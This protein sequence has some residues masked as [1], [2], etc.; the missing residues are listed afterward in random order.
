MY[1][2][3]SISHIDDASRLL[4]VKK[5]L[6]DTGAH[7]GNYIGRRFKNS[8]LPF[9]AGM[10]K[11]SDTSVFLADAQTEL[12]I[13][14]SADLTL[15]ITT[16]SGVMVRISATFFVIDSG[17]DL[18]LGLNDMIL[19]APGALVDMIQRAVL[20]SK[21]EIQFSALWGSTDSPLGVGTAPPSGHTV[22]SPSV[23][24]PHPYFR[25]TTAL[26]CDGG[27]KGSTR[28]PSAHSVQ[29]LTV[30]AQTPAVVGPLRAYEAGT[31]DIRAPWTNIDV[32]APEEQDPPET[33]LF[34]VQ[35][36]AF[37]EMPVSEATAEYLAA[38]SSAPA[39][40]VPF[41]PEPILGPDGMPGPA[42][43]RGRFTP[44]MYGHP[45]FLEYMRTEAIKVFVPQNWEGIRV[46]PIEFQFKASLPEVHYQKAR[47]IPKMRYDATKREVERLC[48]YHLVPSTSSIV[49]AISVADKATHPYIRV[50]GDYRKINEHVNLDHQYIPRVQ[51]ELERFAKFKYFVDLDMVNSFHQFKLGLKTSEVLSLIT[52]WG[53]FRPVFMPEGVSPATGVLQANMREIFKDFSDWAVVIFD[54]FCIGGES[55]EDV[56]SKF[57]LFVERCIL[58]NI[59]LKFSKCYFGFKDVKFFGYLCDGEGWQIDDERKIAIRQ[60]PFP[61]GL[62][63]GDCVTRMQSFL[64]FSLYFRDFVDKYSILAAPLYGM[65]V[66]GFIWDEALWGDNDY[67]RIF[68]EFKVALC[69]C[70]KLIWPNYE[71]PWVLQTDASSVGCG[72]ILFQIRTITDPITGVITTRR[73]P[74]ACIS[75]KFSGA[76]TNWAV[77]KQEMYAIYFAVDKLAYYLRYKSF[78]IQTDHANLVHME[79][80]N[81][82]IMVRWRLFLQSFPIES[83]IH[84]AG[85]LNIAADFFSRIMECDYDHVK[86]DGLVEA[87]LTHVFSA[88]CLSYA[89]SGEPILN[90]LEGHSSELALQFL[91]SRQGACYVPDGCSTCMEI[92]DLPEV[93]DDSYC[94]TCGDDYR[95]LAN[96]ENDSEEVVRQRADKNTYT[97]HVPAWDL[98]LEKIHGGSAMHWAALPTWRILR[99]NFEHDIPFAYVEYYVRECATCQK[100]RKTLNRDRHLPLTRHLKVSGPRSTLG[101]DGFTMTPVDKYGHSYLHVI[102]NYFTKHVFLYVC[103]DK[104]AVTG[105]DAIIT[106]MALFGRHD[107]LQSDPGSDY[108]SNVVAQLNK[109][110]GY[111][112]SFSLVDRPESNGVEPTNRE[113]ARHVKAIV[114]DKGLQEVWSEPRTLAVVAFE[115]NNHLSSESNYTAFQLTFGSGHDEYF[116][117]LGAESVNEI[118]RYGPYIKELDALISK[119]RALSLKY[120]SDLA[121]RRTQD[122]GLVKRNRWQPGDHVLL[123]NVSPVDKMQAP[124][125]GP[126]QVD[127]QS[128]N[129][130]YLKSLV[131]GSVKP[132]HVGRLSL[133]TGTQEEALK[134]ARA[135][136]NQHFIERISGYRGDS[137]TRETMEFLVE[138]TDAPGSWLAYSRDLADTEQFESY[139]DSLPQLRPLISLASEVTKQ[140]AHINKS[141]IADTHRE[142]D[143]IYVDLRA[144][145]IY[146]SEW[147][148]ALG[149]LD[150]INIKHRFARLRVGKTLRLPRIPA[151]TRVELVDETFGLVHTVDPYTLYVHGTVRSID[152][153]PD[154]NE[155]VDADFARAHPYRPINTDLHKRIVRRD[156]ATVIPAAETIRILSRNLNGIRS[157]IAEGFLRELA[158]LPGGPPDILV[159]QET[160]AHA[161]DIAQLE[162]QLRK[163]G[164]VH[165]HLQPGVQSGYAGVAIACKIRFILLESAPIERGRALAVRVYGWTLIIF[166]APIMCT[167]EDLIVDRRAKFDAAALAYVSQL[168]SPQLICGDMNSVSD[169]SLDLSLPLRLRNRFAGFQTANETYLVRALAAKGFVDTFRLINQVEIAYT[170]FPA[171]SWH[172]IKARLDYILTDAVLQREVVDCRV[173]PRT[174]ASDHAGVLLTILKPQGKPEMWPNFSEIFSTP[175]DSFRPVTSWAGYTPQQHIPQQPEVYQV[176]MMHIGPMRNG[177]DGAAPPPPPP[178]VPVIV[179]ESAAD[180]EARAIAL[181][182]VPD[183]FLIAAA[184]A[185]ER[186]A[187]MDAAITL[188]LQPITMPTAGEA[189]PNTRRACTPPVATH[190]LTTPP[191]SPLSFY[192]DQPTPYE[193]RKAKNRAANPA[194]AKYCDDLAA[195]NA[196]IKADT[197]EFQRTMSSNARETLARSQVEEARIAAQR[198]EQRDA[199]LAWR[200]ANPALWAQREAWDARQLLERQQTAVHVWREAN[201]DLWAQRQAWD[202]EQLRLRRAR[203]TSSPEILSGLTAPTFDLSGAEEDARTPEAAR[204]IPL[205]EDHRDPAGLHYTNDH[206]QARLLQRPA[207]LAPTHPP[208]DH[209]TQSLASLVMHRATTPTPRTQGRGSRLGP[210]SPNYVD[211]RRVPVLADASI[212]VDNMP[213]LLSDDDT[214]PPLV[215][216]DRP[217]SPTSIAADFEAHSSDDDGVLV[218]IPGGFRSYM[219]YDLS[220]MQNGP[221]DARLIELQN[222]LNASLR[223]DPF[224]IPT[225]LSGPVT[226]DSWRSI[227]EGG[228]PIPFVD[229]DSF[230]YESDLDTASDLTIDPPLL[231]AFDYH[232]AI[233]TVEI[234]F[235]AGLMDADD[236]IVAP[237]SYW[238]LRDGAIANIMGDA[239]SARVTIRAG[240]LIA[241]F[242]GT[243]ISSADARQLPHG[244][245]NYLIDMQDGTVLDC[246][247]NA[248]ARPALCLASIGNM[249]EGAFDVTNQRF[250]SYNDNNAY[251]H[252]WQDSDGE[253]VA[254]LYAVRQIRGGE[255]VMWHYGAKYVF[256]FEVST[257]ITSSS[258]E[259]VSP[260]VGTARSVALSVDPKAATQPLGPVRR[261]AQVADR[262]LTVLGAEEAQPNAS[263]DYA[264]Q[265]GDDEAQEDAFPELAFDNDGSSDESDAG[266]DDGSDGGSRSL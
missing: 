54:N 14:E 94:E 142:H 177:D 52:P 83:I 172:G 6:W 57:K 263:Q 64:G 56:F 239:L 178:P 21:A 8:N 110:L 100:Y 39:A 143:V 224:A 211:H 183:E 189:D 160:K 238:A 149:E 258:S 93:C 166:Y 58:F 17:C 138:F 215:G 5:L 206:F 205:R 169:I 253:T 198:V 176:W 247:A 19:Q 218:V 214:P 260:D 122:K 42:P 65:T 226:I 96:L 124:R 90:E 32:V 171:G 79:R 246:M 144:R 156:L 106:Y 203:H 252:W 223:S 69:L 109:Y 10:L 212:S 23:A 29:T 163:L 235:D 243:R 194:F 227:Y 9:L 107:R 40:S 102:V 193:A 213:V 229:S 254:T 35:A 148:L 112:H 41:D 105:A 180:E 210:F 204:G 188:S 123:D 50:C 240:T 161:N 74:I 31:H 222:E 77:I 139:C 26:L 85:K 27:G 190:P 55:L 135:D 192:G 119:V 155:I 236:L 157:A 219:S 159:L 237:S 174:P 121:K 71:L 217:P 81:V 82:A 228:T 232:Y 187:E 60:I 45:G 186:E 196:K 257:I 22:T 133:Y 20:F 46:K 80:S 51:H 78:Q 7:G 242:R 67:R 70:F 208:I 103:K 130:V 251:V 265:D 33:S 225:P 244:L 53:T 165:F 116:R 199:M 30:P 158:E 92:C 88:A 179:E 173:L 73:E 38:L 221:M 66:K 184:E 140:K 132:F 129:E 162:N 76:A 200:V 234:N 152:D 48:K 168:P 91:S 201:P 24:A 98:I 44:D 209:L 72:A 216:W 87:A 18:I 248:T 147:Y 250:L 1:T 4:P 245:N 230:A 89:G 231:I 12:K 134:A 99:D 3:A 131:T 261:V 266:S 170:C 97:A 128:K 262:W 195:K 256:G 141:S 181:S 59:F 113:V 154:D 202:A 182:L 37:M 264:S 13:D 117:S 16:Y 233:N 25:P 61:T 249:A 75:H 104:T 2:R 108:T 95:S 126:Y 207:A 164:Y 167:N 137:G 49:S 68:E 111:V 47:P 153:L 120:Q 118:D 220:G 175:R 36:L 114:F 125:L 197:K 146:E 115:I 259:P 101:I 84:L 145:P 150:R 185:A 15:H 136:S 151:G 241:S 63:R 28:A 62:T 191:V 11:H 127:H 34:N 255:E 43:K 86:R